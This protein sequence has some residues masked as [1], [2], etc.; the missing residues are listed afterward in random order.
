MG[1]DKI[2]FALVGLKTEQFATFEDN[3]TSKAKTELK[4]GLEF[5]FNK[6]QKVVAVYVTTIFEQKKKA[7]LKLQ[8]SCHFNISDD[9]FEKFCDDLKIVFPKGFMTHITMISIS[10]VR[11]VLHAKTEGTEFNKYLLPTLDV[12]KMVE[13]DIKFDIK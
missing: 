13:E 2:G 6:E 10:S 1:N 4:T 12:T 11:G 7:F 5:K 9:S 3:F 8:V